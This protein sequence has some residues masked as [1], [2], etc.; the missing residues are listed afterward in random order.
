MVSLG[1]SQIKQITERFFLQSGL[2]EYFQN[3][4]SGIDKFFISD[5]KINYMEIK[6]IELNT[7]P[8][9]HIGDRATSSY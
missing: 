5:L 4:T 3:T 9:K 1:T 6:R 7:A 8:L 2:F